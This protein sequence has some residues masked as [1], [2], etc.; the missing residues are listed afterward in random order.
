MPLTTYTHG[1]ETLRTTSP[2]AT[3]DRAVRLYLSGLTAEETAKRVGVWPE[4]VGK[5]TR[6]LGIVRSKSETA[7]RAWGEEKRAQIDHAV[8]LYEAGMATCKVEEVSGVRASTFLYR[9]RQ[10]G[11]V[12]TRAEGVRRAPRS[13]QAAKRAL[14]AGRLRSEGATYQQIAE[15]L[16]VSCAQA[17]VDVDSPYNPY[18]PDYDG[19]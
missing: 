2:W 19:D 3:V 5:W 4:T 11:T 10:R 1:R 9:A 16:G 18:H 8:S 15:R 6:K 13:R 7:R 14:R 17:H 12:R